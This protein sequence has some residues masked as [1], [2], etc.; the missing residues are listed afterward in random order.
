MVSDWKRK[1][2]HLAEHALWSVLSVNNWFSKAI[3]G[4][5]LLSTL[6]LFYSAIEISWGSGETYLL[7]AKLVQGYPIDNSHK[8]VN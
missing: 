5:N 3:I 7:G 6:E 4:V 8:L 2:L 1:I